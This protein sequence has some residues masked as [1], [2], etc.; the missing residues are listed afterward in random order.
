VEAARALTAGGIRILE[1]TLTVPGAMK[2]IE[3]LRRQFGSEILVG[4]GT[5]LDADTAREAIRHGAQFVVS[6]GLDLGMIECCKESGVPVA[7]GALTP[8]EIIT[9][10]K[11]GADLVKI[12]PAG[13]LGGA[14]YIRSIRGPLPQ[15]PLMPTGGVN[16][17][18]LREF[19]DAG[20]VAVG[21]GSDL[22][23]ANALKNQDYETIENNAR[24]LMAIVQ[25]WKE[26]SG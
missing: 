17:N 22:V 11:A 1:I 3:N 5:V 21:V 15:I 7:P 26:S 24:A 9:A 18:T 13:N 14:K 25:E 8:T 2:V 23:N 6:P 19:L 4:A 16:L 12:F 10:W 20:V